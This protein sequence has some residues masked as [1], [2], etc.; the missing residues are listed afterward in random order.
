ML[1]DAISALYSRAGSAVRPPSCQGLAVAAG[2]ARRRVGSSSSGA[3]GVSVGVAVS[4][5]VGASVGRG[6]SVGCGVGVTVGSG[7]G[8]A[9]ATVTGDG[10]DGGVVGVGAGA[11]GPE[12]AQATAKTSRIGKSSGRANV[13]EQRMRLLYHRH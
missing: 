6:V 8:V 12:G 10:V 3:V 4:V 7:V 11:A 5:G 2:L 9:G 1:A 13:C